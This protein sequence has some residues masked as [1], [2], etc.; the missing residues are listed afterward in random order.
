MITLVIATG[1]A[2]KAGEIRTILGE[3][4]RYLTL[5]DLPGAPTVLEDAPTFAGNAAK[6]ALALADWLTRQHQAS[7]LDDYD[8]DTLV[9]ADDSGLE[10]DAL[11][12]APGVHSARFAALD[13]GRP[14]NSPTAENNA[15][16]LRLLQDV[17]LAERT[18]RFRCALV[19]ARVA[20]AAGP[21]LRAGRLATTQAGRPE[22]FPP[23][24]A[25]FLGSRTVVF[26]GDCPGRIIAEYRGNQGFGYDPLFVPAGYEQT[27]A[28]LGDEVKN[29]LSHRA[30]ALA[31]LRA[32]F[33]Q[34][35]SRANET[36]GLPEKLAGS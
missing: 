17:P 26:E 4:F 12:G 13:D 9:L 23:S 10:V 32:W 18:A 31:K 30:K 8:G 7:G 1:N 21:D 33:D 35:P 34:A 29:T 24:G 16:L 15:K 5:K 11:G 14:G 20:P 25:G 6:K 36:G 22:S 28:E 3:R 19:V 2:H 27:F